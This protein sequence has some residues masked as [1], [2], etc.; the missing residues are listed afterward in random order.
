MFCAEKKD[1]SVWNGRQARTHSTLPGT[2]LKR[3]LVGLDSSSNVM[4]CSISFVGGYHLQRLVDVDKRPLAW[5]RN[6]SGFSQ[7]V[8]VGS[9]KMSADTGQKDDSRDVSV[10]VMI[11]MTFD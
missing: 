2:C 4:E 8:R 10:D 11:R 5:C 1:A 9:F 3:D 6:S 7:M